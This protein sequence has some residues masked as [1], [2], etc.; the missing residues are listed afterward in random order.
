VD[1]VDAFLEA[2]EKLVG[3][4]FAFNVEIDDYNIEREWFDE[5]GKVGVM[6][7]ND[8]MKV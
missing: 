2:L 7:K 5:M 8:E 4:K 1:A 3:R 6:L